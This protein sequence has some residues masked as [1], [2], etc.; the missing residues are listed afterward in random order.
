MSICRSSLDLLVFLWRLALIDNPTLKVHQLPARGF[1]VYSN[2]F[3]HEKLLAKIGRTQKVRIKGNIAEMYFD[4]KA[5][6]A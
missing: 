3:S 1:D 5:S 6:C 4:M 2:V